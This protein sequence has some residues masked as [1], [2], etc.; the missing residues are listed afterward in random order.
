M[1]VIQMSWRYELSYLSI[2]DVLEKADFKR[3]I[4]EFCN[5]KPV[6]TCKKQA[7]IYTH[8]HTITKT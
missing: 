7:H 3:C 2:I 8:T 6:R 1:H 5:S 4:D